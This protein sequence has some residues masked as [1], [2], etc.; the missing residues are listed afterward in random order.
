M[1]EKFTF[2]IEPLPQFANLNAAIRRP[3]VSRDVQARIVL[4]IKLQGNNML[5]I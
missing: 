2:N 5:L 3:R 4:L 1:V